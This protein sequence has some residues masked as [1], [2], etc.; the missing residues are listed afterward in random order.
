MAAGAQELEDWRILNWPLASAPCSPP[1]PLSGHPEPGEES[2]FPGE[3]RSESLA[4]HTA[5]WEMLLPTQSNL[6]PIRLLD[7]STRRMH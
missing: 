4:A 2:S 5:T 3:S 7:S 6:S 1:W